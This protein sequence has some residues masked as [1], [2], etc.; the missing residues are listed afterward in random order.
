MFYM[1]HAEG[2]AH[3]LFTRKISSSKVAAYLLTS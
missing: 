2:K 1:F 3:Y